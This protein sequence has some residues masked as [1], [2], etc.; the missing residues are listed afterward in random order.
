MAKREGFST[1]TPYMIFEDA[2][3][4]CDYYKKA[5]GADEISCHR[6]GAGIIRHAELRIADSPIMLCNMVPEFPEMKAPAKYGGSPM[7]LFVYCDDADAW[8]TR[9]VEHGA[10]V[11]MP[12]DDKDYGR[13]GGVEDPFGYTWWITTHT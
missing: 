13:T 2:N 12:M 7:Q 8:F 3:A 6:D 10:K 4:A 1:I 11:V 5:F 9:A